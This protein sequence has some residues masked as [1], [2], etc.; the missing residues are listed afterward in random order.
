MLLRHGEVGLAGARAALAEDARPADD[1]RGLR[2]CER[3][4]DHVDAEV[5]RGRVDE[6]AVAVAAGELEARADPSGPGVVDVDVGGVVRIRHERVRVGA[7]A[8]LHGRNLD[9]RG[10]VADVE[11]ADTAEAGGVRHVAA[12][13]AL[14]AAVDPAAGLL[15]RHEEE[16]AVHRHVALAAGA[17]HGCP[18]CRCGRIGDVVDVE[19]VEVAR[20]RVVAAE[21]EVR[22]REAQRADVGRVEEP[23]RL[24]AVR[25]QVDPA[26]R[27]ARIEP[28][29]GQA[30]AG[31]GHR[32]SRTRQE[33]NQHERR[34]QHCHDAPPAAP[35]ND[36]FHATPPGITTQN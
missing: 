4:L 15:D 10:D 1:G 26:A 18:Q 33:C 21:R 5:R 34:S 2:R 11:D 30:D 27:L 29:R 9:R 17:D 35:P 24:V 23:D 13:R 16:V 25:E 12:S 32:R 8:G 36:R 3:H 28:P 19:A 7:L 14:R 20:E 6:R 22:V 31:V